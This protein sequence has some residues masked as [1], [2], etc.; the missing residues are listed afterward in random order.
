MQKTK[1][2]LP[3]QMAQKNRA[4]IALSKQI[5]VFL[6]AVFMSFVALYGY[7]TRNSSSVETI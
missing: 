1:N 5:I 7:N 3:G 6:E 4:S 2:I